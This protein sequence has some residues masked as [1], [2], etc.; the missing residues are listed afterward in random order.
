[1]KRLFRVISSR[2]D[3]RQVSV[4]IGQGGVLT[5]GFRHTYHE[6]YQPSDI[7]PEQNCEQLQATRKKEM[8]DKTSENAVTLLLRLSMAW[9]FL[10][11]ASQQVFVSD[12]SVVGF[13]GTS[14]TFHGFFSLFTGPDVAPVVTFFVAYGHL[15]IGLSLLFGLMVR[16]SSIFGIGLMILYWMAHMDFPYISNTTNFLMDEHIVDALVLG[17]LITK[18]AGHMCGMDEWASRRPEVVRHPFLAWAVR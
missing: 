8:T 3:V 14:K 13:L 15:L 6:P 4:E 2:V 5:L 16:L 7:P 12:F 11:A 18:H 10:Y 1:M 17:L 9:I